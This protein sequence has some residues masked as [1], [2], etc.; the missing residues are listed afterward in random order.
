VTRIDVSATGTILEMSAFGEIRTVSTPGFHPGLEAMLVRACNES[1]TAQ[2]AVVLWQAEAEA[3]APLSPRHAP[4]ASVILDTRVEPDGDYLVAWAR[5]LAPLLSPGC[6][7]VMV[8]GG[9]RVDPASDYDTLGSLAAALIRLRLGLFIGVGQAAKA[10]ATQ[11][12][13]EG[14]W[15]GESVWADT[16]TQAYDYLCDQVRQSDVVVVV[17]L[18]AD[19]RD[20]LFSRWGVVTP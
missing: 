9:V 20:E 19:T 18:P 16:P 13:L 17:G 4:Q 6:A 7:T 5:A 8:C 10:L 14:S 15:D 11:V 2:E 1:T 3:Y 12:G